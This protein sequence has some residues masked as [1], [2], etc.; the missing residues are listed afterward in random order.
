M[1]GEEKEDRRG[2]E[3]QRNTGKFEVGSGEK[4]T[5]EARRR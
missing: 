3:V 1:R 5:A 2:A 4:K